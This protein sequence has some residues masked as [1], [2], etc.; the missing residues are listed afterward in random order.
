MASL[1]FLFAVSSAAGCNLVK[2]LMVLTPPECL[3]AVCGNVLTF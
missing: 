3:A 2:C 1:C